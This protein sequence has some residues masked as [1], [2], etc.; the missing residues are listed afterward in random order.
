[1]DLSHSG[2]QGNKYIL[3]STA[4]RDAERAFKGSAAGF[5]ALLFSLGAT[6]E[7]AGQELEEEG[8]GAGLVFEEM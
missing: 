4:R 2:A 8:G 6:I 7:N 3:E 1:M 5:V